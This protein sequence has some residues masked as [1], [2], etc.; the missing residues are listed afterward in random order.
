MEGTLN[1]PYIALLCIYIGMICGA[2]YDG[3]QLCGKVLLRGRLG[4]WVAEAVFVLR[5]G[6]ICIGIWYHFLALRLRI[7][8][9]LCMILGLGIYRAGI[10]SLMGMLI[11]KIRD[12]FGKNREK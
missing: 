1:Q 2:L 9:G 10:R 7:F 3:V 8:Y 12:V 6:G 4:S 5:C 11:A